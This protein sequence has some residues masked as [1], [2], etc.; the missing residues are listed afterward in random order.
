APPQRIPRVD[1]VESR[2]WGRRAP[3][4]PSSSSFGAPQGNNKIYNNDTV[5]LMEESNTNDHSKTQFPYKIKKDISQ[6]QVTAPIRRLQVKAP[7]RKYNQA[8]RRGTGCHGILV[9]AAR[10]P[11]NLF[12]RPTASQK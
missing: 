3:Q 4:S 11:P 9:P 10:N 8:A 2:G 7:A 5:F 1:E 12:G 6:L